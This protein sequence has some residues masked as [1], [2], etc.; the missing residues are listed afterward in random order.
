[1]IPADLARAWADAAPGQRSVAEV[2]DVN[3]YT[4]VM[5]EAGARAVAGAIV[6][7]MQTPVADPSLRSAG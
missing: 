3:H 7:A 4:I 1:M 2:P 6:R 5:G